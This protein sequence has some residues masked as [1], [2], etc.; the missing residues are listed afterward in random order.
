[1]VAI[2]EPTCID[3]ASATTSSGADP[4][5]IAAAIKA[6]PGVVDHGLFIDLISEAII[7]G[8]S[9]IQNLTRER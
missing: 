5:A 1:V 6:L 3:T 2:A 4:P 8:S 7:C 9:G